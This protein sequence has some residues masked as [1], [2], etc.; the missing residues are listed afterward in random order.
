MKLHLLDRSTEISSSFSTTTYE[1]SNFLKTWHYHQE[2]ELVFVL[3][4]TGTLFIGDGVEKFEV[5]DLVLIGK[6]LPHM[7]LNDEIYLKKNASLK[8][9]AIAVHFRKDFLGELFFKTPEMLQILKLF[10]RSC[11]GIKFENVSA[12]LT[13]ELNRMFLLDGF[14]KTI[15]FLEILHQLAKHNQYKLL[16]STGFLDSFQLTEN[17]K[18]DKV[19]E[20]LFNNFT[21]PISLNAVAE[22]AHMN[23]SAFS[24]FFKKMHNKTFSKYLNELRVGYA[25]KLLIVN[26]YNVSRVCY[27]AGFNNISNF[28][29]QFKNIK[30]LTPSQYLQKHK[31]N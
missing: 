17:K 30:G 27:N 31:S 2:L 3:K 23:P 19:Y 29:R 4:S 12:K 14:E 28:N 25:C 11:N 13:E 20:Y 24:R 21:H 5:G 26:N 1:D 8:A 7:W 15:V 16:S 22:I 9:K 18:L 10:K 6:D